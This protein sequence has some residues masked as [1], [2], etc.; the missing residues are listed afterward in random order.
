MSYPNQYAVVTGASRGLGRA[1][2]FELAKCGINTLLVSS[3]CQISA[4]CEE[5]R[6]TYHVDSQY[7]IAD[8]TKRE[9]VISAV[10]EINAKYNVFFLINNAGVGGSQRFDKVDVSY[11]EK[12][13]QLNVTA[14][15]LFCKLLLD[16]LLQ[17]NKSFILNV[18]SMAALT[19]I[20]YKMVYP[21]SKAFVH[22]FSH[23]I[24]AEFRKT[25][26]SVS[27]VCPGAMAT[28]QSICQRIEKQ[29]VF[30]KLTLISPEKVAHRCVRQALR[31][32]REIVV[33]PAAFVF[34]KITPSDIRTRILTHIV[35]K[36]TE[37]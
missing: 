19:P 13:I 2:A 33:N 37:M 3:N 15:T 29:G 6:N 8:L 18:A 14:T 31:G 36:E 28:S 16:N 24:R 26:L 12:I 17:Q 5:L 25:G 23:A 10:D 20:G 34:S 27:V 32:K 21:A 30:G 9:S 1:F 22:N 4:L 35:K 7:V 11:L